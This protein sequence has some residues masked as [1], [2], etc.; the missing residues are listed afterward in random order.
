M[1]SQRLLLRQGTVITM[2]DDLGDFAAADVLVDD[3]LIVAVAP[4]LGPVDAE[5]ID[6]HGMI[7]LPGF[8]DTHRHT[9]QAA[10]R[11]LAADWTLGQYM[12]GLHLG[13]SALFRPAD[14]YAGN[15]L[16]A[17]EALDSGITTML[18]WSHNVNTPEHSDAA[19]QG[20]L[21]SGIR[22]VFA[23]GGGADMY[24]VPSTVPHDEDVRRVRD[25]YF[26]SDDQLCTMAM[27]LRGPQFATLDVTASD[28]RLARELGLPVTLHVGD[29][30]WGRSR[31]VTRMKERG[32]LGPDITY[33]HCNTLA[34]EEL[35]DI[36][37]SG[38]SVSISPD[39]E[40]QM[41]HGWPAT[42]RLMRVGIRPSLSID[43]CVSNSGHMFGTM[44]VCLATQRAIDNEEPGASDRASVTLGSRDVLSFAT[45]DGARA[46]GLNDKV[47]SLT[48]GKQADIVLLRAD[49]PSLAPL[50]NPVGQV[51]YSAHPGLVDTVLVAGRVVKS[52]GKLHGDL[53]E[54]AVRLGEASRDSLFSR[55][56]DTKNLTDARIGGTWQPAP[57]VTTE[58]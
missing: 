45:R 40:M 5:S 6:A 58:L 4:D 11:G 42:G 38:G 56:R 41:G 8:V 33:V 49:T 55:T 20:L 47:G 28:L 34:D 27:A 22:A 46:C 36:A 25:R 29:G 19:V 14:T 21:E 18:D 2:D 43:T 23:H 9:W 53:A 48:P 37:D 17:V 13:L 15:L 24:Q 30:E 1:R 10:L 50:N 3:G 7:V 52:G 12:T 44:Q 39:I 32:L 16:G 51:V 57:L 26:P 31:P 54:R 35:R